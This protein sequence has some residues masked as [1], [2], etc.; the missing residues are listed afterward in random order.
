M[1]IPMVN[2]LAILTAMYFLSRICLSPMVHLIYYVADTGIASNQT[3]LS[4]TVKGGGTAY[5]LDTSSITKVDSNGTTTNPT[6]ISG[7][8]LTA[9]GA[10]AFNPNH[11]DFDGLANGETIQ[12]SGA[13]NYTDASSEAASNQ[14]IITITSDGVYSHSNISIRIRYIKQYF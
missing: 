13:Y 11:A 7:F 6:A 5:S 3:G 12:I 1:N 2:R 10:L 9:N 8:S 14:F 4:G